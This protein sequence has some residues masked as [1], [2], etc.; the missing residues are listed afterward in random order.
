MNDEYDNQN[1]DQASLDD[2]PG[3]Y[4]RIIFQEYVG[5]PGK[6]INDG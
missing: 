2:M 1:R 6:D 4:C 3:H 5:N